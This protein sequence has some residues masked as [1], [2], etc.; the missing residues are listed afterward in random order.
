MAS[1]VFHLANRKLLKVTLIVHGDSDLNTLV[2]WAGEP[3]LMS[4][5]LI[6]PELAGDYLIAPELVLFY[7]GSPVLFKT[8]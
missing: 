7:T 1:I 3:E 5:Y 2:T 8:Q 4:E 6:A